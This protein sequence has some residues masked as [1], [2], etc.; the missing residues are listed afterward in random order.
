MDAVKFQKSNLEEKF[1]ESAL[2]RPYN[3]ANAFGA[4]YGDHKRHLE[5]SCDQMRSLKEY[6][7]L[8]GLDFG[9]SPMD[10][11]SIKEMIEM[12]P[13]FIK[14]GSGDTNNFPML[15][16]VAD[17]GLPVIISTGMQKQSTIERAV[18]I[19][20]QKTDNFAVLHCIS[21]YPTEVQDINLKQML[22]LKKQYPVVG[23]SGHE[24]G[25][26]P[27]LAAVYLGARI[28]ERHFTLDKGMKG[29]DHKC[30]LDPVDMKGFVSIVRK[31]EEFTEGKD[32]IQKF[33]HGIDFFPSIPESSF[34]EYIDLV[35][36]SPRG[37]AI[38]PCEQPCFDKLGKTVV[39]KR[40]L[41]SGVILREDDL[42]IKVAEEK[43]VSAEDHG[44]IIS[45]KLQ[46]DVVKDQVVQEGYLIN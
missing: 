9:V 2:N 20:Q 26:F 13:D 16:T 6:S 5:F 45:R 22:R 35:S 27:S 24:L 34:H 23:Y 4:T 7:E 42:C 33:H 41:R 32:I 12:K 1:T 43:G 19:I 14:I 25:F 39:F 17:C 28:I 15:R 18:E 29:S 30:S 8:I 3:S 44:G 10:P 38:Y 11:L 21:S 31:W 36:G 40:A 37:E 46:L